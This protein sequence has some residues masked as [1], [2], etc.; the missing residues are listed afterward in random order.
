MNKPFD[1]R[2]INELERPTSSD[3][4]I[5]QSQINQNARAMMRQLLQPNAA[6]MGTGSLGESF[7]VEKT[8]GTRNFKI[9]RGVGFNNVAYNATTDLNVDGITGVSDPLDYRLVS[10]QDEAGVAIVIPAGTNTN[11][12]RRDVIAIRCGNPSLNNLTDYGPT[13][14]YDTGTNLFGT[15]DRYKTF[16]YDISG[17]S[18]Q[19][20]D[21]GDIASATDPVVYIRGQTV[22]Y[23]GPDSLLAAPA[24]VLSSP[25]I[26]IA[27]V[28]I[29][30]QTDVLQSDVVDFRRL[31]A[32]QGQITLVGAATVGA[33]GASPGAVLSTVSLVGSPGIKAQILKYAAGSANS[34]VLIVYGPRNVTSATINYTP[35]TSIDAYA[36]LASGDSSW[37][38]R[39]T[40]VVQGPILLNQGVDED[41]KTDAAN[42]AI[43][44]PTQAV[45]IGQPYHIFPFTLCRVD[46][47]TSTESS[48]ITGTIS[49]NPLV[50]PNALAGA[51]P[52]GSYS[53]TITPTSETYY[54]TTGG[55]SPPT[56]GIP[57]PVY[58]IALNPPSLGSELVA[59][60]ETSYTRIAGFVLG[61]SSLWQSF[62]AGVWKF[63][64]YVE[65][66][67]SV[68]TQEVYL[69][70][71]LYA[72]DGS[73]NPELGTP[74]AEV[75]DVI[76]SNGRI[77]NYVI[78]GRADFTMYVPATTIAAGTRMYIKLEHKWAV[79]GNP[80]D[81]LV[82]KAGADNP[83]VVETNVPENTT[84]TTTITNL[85]DRYPADT[86]PLSGTLNASSISVN[87]AG[88]EQV[89]NPSAISFG[90]KIGEPVIRTIP[91]N[92]NL[93]MTVA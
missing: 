13:D 70:A 10:A 87:V 39:P 72:Y 26:N 75:S 19:V 22:A 3:L 90:S 50:I 52:A 69:K 77:V 48:P 36:A 17:Q 47:T 12:C 34:Y 61:A 1:Q 81:Q 5:A 55:A 67:T 45:A 8:T 82:I 25:Y 62:A 24:P 11:F 27:I 15:A 20:L 89:L 54:L 74:I 86:Y 9:K 58:G 37:K 93:K 14:I 41:L 18:P 76:I 35:G 7:F 56:T 23:T 66:T 42:A 38:V 64:P 83:F 91:V 32:P 16:T 71:S 49:I 21:Y 46:N 65:I 68:P 33:S 80:G 73:S 43:A 40:Q 28:N 63:S 79:A 53:T 31:V 60:L 57:S 4:N 51:W 92:F 30:G 59:T 44:A 85:E 29:Y 84:V 2:V 78:A 88:Q 6:V